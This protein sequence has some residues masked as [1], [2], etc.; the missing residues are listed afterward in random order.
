MGT[1]RIAARAASSMFPNMTSLDV[2]DNQ[3]GSSGMQAFA[4]SSVFFS[5][6]TSFIACDNNIADAELHAL[7]ASRFFQN[8][9]T[10]ELG[11]N[12]L[13]AEGMQALAV[14]PFPNSRPWFW[15]RTRLGLQECKRL[16][17]HQ[18]FPT[19]HSWTC[20]RKRSGMK[21]LRQ[22]PLRLPFPNLRP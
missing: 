9:A 19:S 18:N 3:I 5:E 12:Q 11:S 2:G 14:S 15:A 21:G 20:I 22:F 16:R 7:A 17:L 8:L 10:L 13:S 4:A 1:G 6:L